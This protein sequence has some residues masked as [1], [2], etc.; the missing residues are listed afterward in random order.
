[1]IQEITRYPLLISPPEIVRTHFHPTTYAL[2]GLS[3]INKIY[4][5]KSTGNSEYKLEEE[6]L[7]QI[8]S[9][10]GFWSIY[11]GLKQL[12]EKLASYAD[13]SF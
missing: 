11:G 13:K 9:W 12:S 6:K 4:Y 7:F 3:I 5:L 8:V 1:M 2:N 10:I